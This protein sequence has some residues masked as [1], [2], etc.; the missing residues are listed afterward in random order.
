MKREGNQGDF[1]A[2]AHE[3]EEGKN[4]GEHSADKV[5]Q[6]GADQ[7]SHTFDI[8]HDAGDQVAGAIGIVKA[9]PRG[10]QYAAEPACAGRR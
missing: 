2:D 10:G 5:D 9:A 7:V 3:D 8:R 1:R 6:P 4:G